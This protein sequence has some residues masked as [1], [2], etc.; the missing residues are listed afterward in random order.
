MLSRPYAPAERCGDKVDGLLKKVE[1]E[2]TPFPRRLTARHKAKTAL[3]RQLKADAIVGK[4]NH[5]IKKFV[6]M[7][8]RA[9]KTFKTLPRE[10]GTLRKQKPQP[11]FTAKASAFC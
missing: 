2:Q 11:L 8:H 4:K 6:D 7:C 9:K 10:A 3:G 1:T 5:Q